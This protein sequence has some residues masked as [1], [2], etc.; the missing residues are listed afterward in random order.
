[1]TSEYPEVAVG[2]ARW[3]SLS[4][5]AWNGWAR[6]V[7]FWILV[8]LVVWGVAQ[9]AS[10]F[11][12]ALI[13]HGVRQGLNGDTHALSTQGF[14][15][16]LASAIVAVALGFLVAFG[17]LHALA[18]SF[19]L[20]RLR[21]QVTR[22]ADMADFAESYDETR[23]LFEAHPLLGHAWKEFDETLVR[24]KDEN[25]IRNTVRPQVFIN[26]A[27]ARDQLFGLKMMGSIPGYFVGI[28]LLLTFFGLVLALNKAA[29]AVSGSDAAAMQGAT[30]DLLQVATFK[31]AT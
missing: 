9:V 23:D 6:I 19:P 13:A 14:A 21:R 18:I 31:F 7:A 26:L 11:D 24:R 29:A 28:G 8:G 15:F 2:G 20:W 3:M 10:W 4:R 5:L 17:L 30:R 27:T 1:M 22:T 12:P 16:A 25:V